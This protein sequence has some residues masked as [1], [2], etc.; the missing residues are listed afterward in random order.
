MVANL[1]APHVPEGLRLVAACRRRLP[2]VR[3]E[4]RKVGRAIFSNSPMLVRRDCSRV[5]AMDRPQS[6]L[7]GIK[8]CWVND[9]SLEG[10][11]VEEE[12]ESPSSVRRGPGPPESQ[13]RAS[14]LG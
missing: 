13:P 10:H 12:D 9:G 5:V 14:R 7:G 6:A 1:A 8:G 2:R 11:V 3:E 4:S